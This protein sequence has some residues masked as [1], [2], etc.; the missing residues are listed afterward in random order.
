MEIIAA[1]SK[2]RGITF[3]L[4][5][6]V[7]SA[8]IKRYGILNPFAE[9]AFGP[10]R[11]DPGVKAN[12]EKYVSVV[13]ARPDQVGMAFPGTFVLDRQGRV[14]SRFF[15]DFYIDR[16]TV[17]SLSDQTGRE[18]GRIRRGHEDL[19]EPSGRDHLIRAIRQWPREIVFRWSW[20][21]RRTPACTSTHRARR[22]PA[23]ALFHSIC[24]PDP[25]I[26]LFPVQ[27]PASEIYYFK[28][29]HQRVPVFQKPFRLVQELLLDG[30]PARQEALRGKQELILTGTLQYQACDDK[31]LLQPRLGPSHVEAKPAQSHSRTPN[32]SALGPTAPEDSAQMFRAT[33]ANSST[34]GTAW[35]CVRSTDFWSCYLSAVRGRDLPRC[36]LVLE[37]VRIE[38]VEPATGRFGL[39]IHEETNRRTHR[40]GQHHIMREVISHPIHLPRPK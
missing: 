24:E 39:G 28:P 29:L 31:D 18:D 6:D 26:H 32:G 11:N 23:I 38:T 3:P 22:N 25:Q 30:T 20:K 40:F 33:V 13:G 16:N 14:T 9:Q 15:E 37:A 2:Q 7:G 19:D 34:T 17:S 5:S 12:V 36:N 10:N 27:Y 4:L 21:W 1:F 35:P 8:T